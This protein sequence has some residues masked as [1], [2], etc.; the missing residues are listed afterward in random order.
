MPRARESV[1]DSPPPFDRSRARRAGLGRTWQELATEVDIQAV[2]VLR[3]GRR[4]DWAIPETRL[5]WLDAQERL[6]ASGNGSPR[7]A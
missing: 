6:E 4:R 7:E 3:R 5:L 2:Q 1:L